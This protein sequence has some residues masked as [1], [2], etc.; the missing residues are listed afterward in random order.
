MIPTTGYAGPEWRFDD[1]KQAI[2]GA[3]EGKIAVLV[4][5]GV[6]AVE[7]PWVHTEPDEFVKYMDYLK[8]EGCTV[9]AMRDLVRYVD[10]AKGPPDPYAPIRERTKEAAA[11][12]QLR[13]PAQLAAPR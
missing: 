6:P 4:F 7:H 13:I 12:F 2:S 11:Q 3:R 5:H 9:I 10:P 1:L 8:A